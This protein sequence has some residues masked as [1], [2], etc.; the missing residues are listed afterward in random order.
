MT[1][2]NIDLSSFVAAQALAQLDDETKNKLIT[3]AIAS[4]IDS[5]S[6]KKII[7]DEA[8]SIAK[9]EVKAILSGDTEIRAKM[10]KIVNEAFAKLLGDEES[11]KEKLCA[12]LINSLTKERY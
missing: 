11:L 3:D 6:I 8:L 12:G 1:S 7:K 4:V 2:V 9:E 10:I 5:E